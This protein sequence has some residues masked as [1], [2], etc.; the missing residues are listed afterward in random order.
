MEDAQE[1]SGRAGDIALPGAAADLQRDGRHVPRSDGTAFP[2]SAAAADSAAGAGSRRVQDVA[3]IPSSAVVA[4]TG[5]DAA[6]AGLNLDRLSAAQLLEVAVDAER[7]QDFASVIAS[8]ALAAFGR[9]ELADRA[10]DHALETGAGSRATAHPD[11]SASG[12]SE[13]EAG[14][15]AASTVRQ[16]AVSAQTQPAAEEETGTVAFRAFREAVSRG[17]PRFSGDEVACALDVASRT[18]KTRLL[19][20]MFA[21]AC[22]PRALALVKAG[23]IDRA[24]FGFLITQTRSL[25]AHA[26]LELDDLV[27]SW[28]NGLSRRAFTRRVRTAVA[29]A[30]ARD[31]A[32]RHAQVCQDR[33]VQFIPVEDGAAILSVYGPA[34]ALLTAYRR[35]DAAARTQSASPAGPGSTFG[36]DATSGIASASGANPESGFRGG[37]CVGADG[38]TLAQRRFDL[39]TGVDFGP[40]G[41]ATIDGSSGTI[42]GVT[43]ARSRVPAQTRVNVTVPALTLL[44]LANLPGHLDGYGPIPPA[45]ATA[46]AA[47]APTWTRILTDPI[48]GRILNTRQYSYRPDTETLRYLRARHTTCTVPCCTTPSD[49]AEIDHVVPFDHD[50]P[51]RGGPTNAWNLGPGCKNHHQGKTL[52]ILHAETIGARHGPVT[53]RWHLPSGRYYDRHEDDDPIT[54]ST[55]TR[56]LQALEAG[57]AQEQPLAVPPGGPPP[58]SSETAPQQREGNR[59]PVDTALPPPGT[60]NVPQCHVPADD[61]PPF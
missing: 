9:N 47:D 20:A 27:A 36:L 23:T 48:T 45:M 53:I 13:V 52:G 18:G 38:R 25:D 40:D 5:L 31:A 33:S 1:H 61:P 60:E 2:A 15:T 29:V 4:G 7:L 17:L 37:E 50:H 54:A 46:I 35:L 34:D 26:A 44:G 24:R 58:P 14:R 57:A 3:V 12:T 32:A 22:F 8:E 11:S 42:N 21:S 28:P 6:L 19:D 41:R 39:L 51:D 43:G 10:K 56:I 49:R 55:S 30:D 59:F 16:H